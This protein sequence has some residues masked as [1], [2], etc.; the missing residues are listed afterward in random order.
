M[1]KV[2]IEFRPSISDEE[3]TF[4]VDGV[5]AYNIA[6]TGLSE[7]YPVNFVLREEGGQLLGG[8][9]GLLWGGWLHVSYLWV[10]EA[11]RGQGFGSRLLGEAEA[12]ARTRGAMGATLETYSFQA[13]PF[14]KRFGYEECG[15]LENYP[16]GGAKFFLKKLLI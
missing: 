11:A 15:T 5:D 12:Y 10:T 1:E 4:I 2:R 6:A 7:W 3:R 13:K 9:I 16:P 8:L 14:Y